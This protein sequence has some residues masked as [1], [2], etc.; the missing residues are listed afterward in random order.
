[1]ATRPDV[2]LSYFQLGRHLE[3]PTQTQINGAHHVI[4]YLYGTRE[5][6][7]LARISSAQLGAVEILY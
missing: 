3:N 4:Q 6:H 5:K 2:A 7:F 1:M